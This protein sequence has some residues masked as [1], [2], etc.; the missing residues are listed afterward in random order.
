MPT[1]DLSGLDRLTARFRNLVN[2]DARPLMEGKAGWM[3]IIEED[4]R[5][6]LLA[7]T[8]RYGNPMIPVTYRPKPPSGKPSAQQRN[9]AN[10]RK[11]RGVFAG[12]GLHAAGLNNNLTMAEYQRLTG[13][14]LIPRFQ[15]SRLI[16]NLKTLYGRASSTMWEAVGYWDE[17]VN[18]K[19]LPFMQYHFNGIGQKR[20]DARGVRPEGKV[21]AKKAMRNWIISEIRRSA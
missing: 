10:A 21:K 15:F 20:R 11:K 2:P 6:G 4:N 19:G 13:P 12:L 17:I 16:T 7:G 5:K 8:D 18:K 14:P 9:M 3:A 1:T